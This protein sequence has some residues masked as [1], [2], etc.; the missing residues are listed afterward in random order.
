MDS[1]LNWDA[2]IHR[3]IDRGR[4]MSRSLA[5]PMNGR[6]KLDPY[7]MIL[8]YK[9]V[10]R[11][12]L[13]YAAAVWATV[14]KSHRHKL[15]TF[16]NRTLR[17]ALTALRYVRNTTIHQDAGIEPLMDFI[18]TIATQVFDRATDHQNPLVPTSQEYDFRIPGQYPGP[19]GTQPQL[20]TQHPISSS[21]IKLTRA[22]GGSSSWRLE[23][24]PL[25]RSI[26]RH[27]FS[28]KENS[29]KRK[30]DRVAGSS[31]DFHPDEE[32]EEQHGLDLVHP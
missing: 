6:S 3:V 28:V 30:E 16:R 21:T 15:Q 14:A 20:V 25:W 13:T 8:L 24:V 10:V 12:M 17:W 32:G 27:S 26:K 23:S 29:S 4:Q 11:P 7:R 18:R 1:R 19:S 2:H 9:A 5:P 22:E 31:E